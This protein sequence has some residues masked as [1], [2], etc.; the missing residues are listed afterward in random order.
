MQNSDYFKKK[1][2]LITPFDFEK[3]KELIMPFVIDNLENME[4]EP[5]NQNP[6]GIQTSYSLGNA[7]PASILPFEFISKDDKQKF[8]LTLVGG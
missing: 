3:P 2:E 8:I 5:A 4:E 6:E 1:K 7:I